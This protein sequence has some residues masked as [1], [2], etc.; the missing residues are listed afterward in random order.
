MAKFLAKTVP[1][2]IRSEMFK[3]GPAFPTRTGQRWYTW[4]YLARLDKSHSIKVGITNN[5]Q[6]RDYEQKGKEMYW[7]WSMPTSQLVEK[8][9]KQILHEF[10]KPRKME[11]NKEPGYTEIIHNVPIQPL[12]LLVRLIILY[13]YIKYRFIKETTKNYTELLA[14]LGDDRTGQRINPNVIR[15]KGR[16]YKGYSDGGNLVAMYDIY[17][18]YG[19][20]KVLQY[21][22]KVEIN[23]HLVRYSNR[24][25]V[26]ISMIKKEIKQRMRLRAQ[27]EFDK[28]RVCD[29]DELYK[30]LGFDMPEL[31]PTISS[32]ASEDESEDE[33]EDESEDESEA[34]NDVQ[35]QER[36]DNPPTVSRHQTLRKDTHVYIAHK[37]T[38]IPESFYRYYL[39]RV[40]RAYRTPTKEYTRILYD[41]ISESTSRVVDKLPGGRKREAILMWNKERTDFR[42]RKDGAFGTWG[43]PAEGDPHPGMDQ[44][45]DAAFKWVD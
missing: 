2:F 28:K 16:D 35:M 19:G 11:E 38:E 3:G 26:S 15:Y 14:P 27:E 36:N 25:N 32:S 42:D 18:K 44:L 43:C 37:I 21:L 24:H 39:A 34:N 22:D 45:S 30:Q 17:K 12:I 4:L 33:L 8:D 7:A 5:L 13:V 41:L 29:L 23:Q 6:R 1:E 10:T 40:Y 20:T 31:G 9:V